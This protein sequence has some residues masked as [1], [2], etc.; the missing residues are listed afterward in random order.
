M[1][2]ILIIVYEVRESKVDMW[3]KSRESICACSFCVWG[4]LLGKAGESCLGR[5]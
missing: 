2:V 3:D 4:F 1:D 5:G